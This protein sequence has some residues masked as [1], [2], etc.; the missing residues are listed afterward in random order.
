MRKRVMVSVVIIFKHTL[1]YAL[2]TSVFQKMS[3]GLSKFLKIF[4]RKFSRG[5]VAHIKGIDEKSKY[6]DQLF[7]C[8]M[9]FV[10]KSEEKMVRK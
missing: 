1:R 10:F 6:I 3:D 2:C 9:L 8:D 5:N 4:L 7:A